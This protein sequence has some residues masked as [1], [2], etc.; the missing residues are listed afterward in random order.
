MSEI[1]QLLAKALH[2]EVMTVLFRKDFHDLAKEPA[3]DVAMIDL[4]GECW[5]LQPQPDWTITAD[6]EDNMT[7][8]ATE[9]YKPP[10]DW[11]WVATMAL[12]LVPE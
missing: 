12:V 1:Q 7:A 6:S 5:R 2:V 9:P 8:H 11:C 4:E 10:A 3:H